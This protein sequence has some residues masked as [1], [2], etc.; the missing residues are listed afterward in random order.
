[1]RKMFKDTL[2]SLNIGAGAKISFDADVPSSP[3]KQVK[4]PKK[5]ISKKVRKLA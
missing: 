1:M 5:V 3:V 2:K 4:T